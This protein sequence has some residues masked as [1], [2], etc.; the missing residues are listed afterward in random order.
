MCYTKPSMN[1]FF[2]TSP[3]ILQTLIWP[4]T[5]FL[6]WF[7]GRLEVR[8]LENLKMLDGRGTIFAANHTSE[9]DPILI[10][11]SL[12]FLSRFMPMFY[13]SREPLFYTA[14]GW[15]NFFYGGFLFEVWG[16]HPVFPGLRNYDLSLKNHLAL[17]SAGKSVCI[18]PEGRRTRD[19]VLQKGKGGVAYLAH[20]T[21][22]PIVPVAITGVFKITPWQFFTGRRK[23]GVVFGAPLRRTDLFPIS[24]G[25]PPSVTEC[26]AAAQIVMSKIA[27]IL[28]T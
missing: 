24:T 27:E 5:R 28:S 14:S 19:G 13:T 1:N 15:R 16:S 25:N 18:F 9:L 23:I 10:P 22:A 21:D 17:L 3:L 2:L 12:P 7:F 8:G 20:A 4:G 11:A 26:E 6:L